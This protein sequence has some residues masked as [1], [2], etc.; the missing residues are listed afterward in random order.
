MPCYYPRQ[1]YRSATVNP[2]GKR[3]LVFN[4]RQADELDSKGLLIKCCQC[5]GCRL[6]RSRNWAIRCM[7]EASLHQDNCFITLTY[8]DEHLPEYGNLQFK[9]FQ[10]FMKR[11]RKCF[12]N[13]IRFFHC[14]EYGDQFSRP[15]YH[16]ILFNHD[17]Y[18]KVHWRTT[19]RGDDIYISK[20]LADLW[21]FGHHEIGACTFESAA[22][23]ARYIVKKRFGLDADDHYEFLD[24]YGEYKQR[25][26]EYITMSRRPGI[27]KGWFDKYYKDVYPEDH[28]LIERNGIKIPVNPP[29]YYD[30]AYEIVD[31]FAMEDVKFQRTKNALLYQQDNQFDR[32]QV[33]EQIQLMKLRQLQRT[34]ET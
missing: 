27:A 11:L 13:G 15:H 8:A 20:T 3:S 32:L 26:R 22:Y 12:G 21:P 14:G 16:A 31:P 7:H 6:T 29:N 19:P 18:D 1:A 23:V 17:F 28:V 33:R 4:I 5:I 34:Y 25:P 9:D 24:E 10:D 30:R 2:S